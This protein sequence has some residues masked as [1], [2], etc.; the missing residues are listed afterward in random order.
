MLDTQPKFTEMSNY[1]HLKIRHKQ[2][3]SGIWVFFLI[4]PI[5][6]SDEFA[7]IHEIFCIAFFNEELQNVGRFQ[8]ECLYWLL[9]TWNQF[10]GK[11]CYF[12]FFSLFFKQKTKR[13]EP[14]QHFSKAR[15]L[16]YGTVF[17]SSICFFLDSFIT[18]NYELHDSIRWNRYNWIS[19][20][21]S[22]F[23]GTVEY[24]T[25]RS[26]GAKPRG[27]KEKFEAWLISKKLCSQAKGT[28]EKTEERRDVSPGS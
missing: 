22:K 3:N 17:T 13:M 1:E 12:H 18:K 24:C 11:M 8:Q 16:F 14:I 2:R 20:Y 19:E 7:K 28:T 15:N 23:Y 6:T 4:W 10:P 5:W 26:S 9:K 21:N 25:H 27:N